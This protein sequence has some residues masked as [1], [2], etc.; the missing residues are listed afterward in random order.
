MGKNLLDILIVIGNTGALMSYLTIVGGTTSSL[1]FGWGATYDSANVYLMTVI[2]TTIFV[3]PLCLN[4]YYGHLGG[5]SFISITCI[6]I[7]LLVVIC[8]GP[9]FG[10]GG[11]VQT[12]NMNGMFQKLGSIIFALSCIPATFHA[13]ES[14]KD[15]NL[16]KFKYIMV[17]Y[18]SC[19]VLV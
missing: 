5:I 18:G 17:S 2:T 9:V 1:L 15:V 7:V 13:Y 19:G 11:E 6:T 8:A 14:T 12:V 16:D 3:L 4:R 10:N